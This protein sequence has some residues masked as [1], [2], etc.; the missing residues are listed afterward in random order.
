M[1]VLVPICFH[2]ADDE[3]QIELCSSTKILTLVNW[4]N[5]H[6]ELLYNC[7]FDMFKW[8]S[9]NYYQIQRMRM[10]SDSLLMYLTGTWY[11]HML[12]NKAMKR[13]VFNSKT[14]DFTPHIEVNLN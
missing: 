11:E 1:R 14:N 2:S 6:L 7:V 12:E 4:E 8:C 10:R 3:K 9:F 5:Q 13:T